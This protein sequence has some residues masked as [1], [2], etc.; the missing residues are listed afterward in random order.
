MRS[1][2]P[3]EMRCWSSR[4]TRGWAR[5]EWLEKGGEATK[6][7]PEQWSFSCRWF[8]ESIQRRT[9]PSRSS[10]H[11][12]RGGWDQFCANKFAPRSIHLSLGR[13]LKLWHLRS[14]FKGGLG[15]NFEPRQNMP[16]WAEK[17]W[18]KFLKYRIV[19]KIENKTCRNKYSDQFE[20]NTCVW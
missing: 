20:T 17:Y 7:I 18:S 3:R 4:L 13:C 5:K 16:V 19:N 8:R 9:T 12:H 15:R 1:Q 14:V 6:R 2:L 11:R 10:T